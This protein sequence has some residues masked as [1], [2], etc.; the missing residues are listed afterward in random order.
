[1]HF[2]KGMTIVGTTGG[3]CLDVIALL[4]EAKGVEKNAI[5]RAEVDPKTLIEKM[6]SFGIKR[7]WFVE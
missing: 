3:C 7:E 1:M 4:R 5:A 2:V 6:K